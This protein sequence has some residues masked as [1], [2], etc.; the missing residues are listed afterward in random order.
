MPVRLMGM[1]VVMVRREGG[2]CNDTAGNCAA[3]KCV[4]VFLSKLLICD[5]DIRRNRLRIYNP[6]PSSQHPP[7]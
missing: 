6:S 1:N 4:E 3:V 7:T 2:D 5:F